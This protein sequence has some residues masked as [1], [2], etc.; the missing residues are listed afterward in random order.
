MQ[1]ASTVIGYWFIVCMGG[2]G[3]G[4][5]TAIVGIGL[6]LYGNHVWKRLIRV[7]HLTVIYYWLDRLEKEGTHCFTKAKDA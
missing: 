6:W 1:Q 2:V 5:L 4:L 7:Y 3:I